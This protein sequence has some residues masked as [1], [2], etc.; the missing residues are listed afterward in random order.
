MDQQKCSDF[1]ANTTP[2][3]DTVPLQ[4]G[5]R[6]EF[7]APAGAIGTAAPPGNTVDP[8]FATSLKLRR[9]IVRVLADGTPRQPQDVMDRVGQGVT[10]AVLR[11][12]LHALEAEGKI[13]TPQ[14]GFWVKANTSATSTNNAPVLQTIHIPRRTQKKTLDR[15]GQPIAASV[16]IKELGV[17]RQRIYQILHKLREL[18]QAKRVR[19]PVCGFGHRWLWL[20]AGV[21]VQDALSAARLLPDT[22]LD[23]L[24]CLEP[25]SLYSVADVARAVRR[26]LGLVRQHIRHLGSL[27]LVTVVKVG[28]SHYVSITPLGLDHPRRS[29]DRSN[30]ATSDPAK[31]FRNRRLAFLEKLAVLREAR[32]IDVTAALAGPDSPATALLSGAMIAR[33]VQQGLAEVVQQDSCKRR[34]YRLTKAGRREASLLARLRPP[35]TREQLEE[36]MAAFRDQQRSRWRAT[37]SKQQKTVF[38]MARTRAQQA[39]LD[40]LAEHPLPG[41]AICAVVGCHVTNGRRAYMMLRTLEQRGG[42]ER[43]GKQGKATVWSLRRIADPASAAP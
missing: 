17:S 40:A 8:K 12:Q 21:N 27:G 9:R 4:A 13:L 32:T 26:G 39:I 5:F 42:V 20:R 37:A 19:V 28:Q 10:P 22:G 14:F 1:D 35:P 24:N 16:L 6:V 11:R 2:S 43:I 38:R 15:L 31:T 41:P 23:I 36:R 7:E 30:V 29:V 3:G 18:G 34:W 25:D 33:L